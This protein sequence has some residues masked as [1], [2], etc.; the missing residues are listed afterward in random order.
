MVKSFISVIIYLS[1]TR[2]DSLSAK[3]PKSKIKISDLNFINENVID[4]DNR[5]DSN[6]VN[7]SLVKLVTNLTYSLGTQDVIS[8]FL[9]P[10]EYGFILES[11]ANKKSQMAAE[12][13]GGFPSAVRMRI[14]FRK[15][16]TKEDDIP[17]IQESLFI[18]PVRIEGEFMFD[19]PLTSDYLESLASIGIQETKIGDVISHG[20][21]GVT[22]VMT[23]DAADICVTTLNSVRGVPVLC[24]KRELAEISKPVLSKE[25]T[26]IEAST[27]LDALGSCALKLSRS[28]MA[29]MVE[30][31]FV[32]VNHKLTKSPALA[33]HVN[34]VVTV[35]GLGRLCLLEA[36]MTQKGR[37]RV[38]IRRCS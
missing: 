2:Y 5:P 32:S 21:R 6:F 13:V 12:L 7:M 14:L 29:K 27:R 17:V 38:K 1:L 18:V 30:E 37:Y 11:L 36:E 35:T 20:E 9:N 3:N 8:P 34:D 28:R 24:S 16:D 15:A 25:V 26:S 10:L 31:G 19:R 33:L 4:D 22:I 23:P